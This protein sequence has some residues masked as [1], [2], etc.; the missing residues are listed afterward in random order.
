ML[1]ASGLVVRHV[2]VSDVSHVQLVEVG[3]HVRG[4]HVRVFVAARAGGAPRER[5]D[6]GCAPRDALPCA[7]CSG[8]HVFRRSSSHASRRVMGPGMPT[9]RRGV[10][11]ERRPD[12]WTEAGARQLVA[13]HERDGLP[14]EVRRALSGED[15]VHRGLATAGRSAACAWRRIVCAGRC[16]AGEAG[17]RR[18]RSRHHGAAAA[19]GG[20]PAALEAAER[21]PRAQERDKGER[22]SLRSRKHF[23]AGSGPAF[24]LLGVARRLLAPW[25]T[26][27]VRALSPAPRR[28]GNTPSSGALPWPELRR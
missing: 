10:A 8:A 17:A 26:A 15:G 12:A 24:R 19:H 7:G 18:Q 11:R 27:A 14:V 28:G 6:Q 20:R 16:G 1:D 5:R 9:W 3:V 13:A 23:F 4:H 25:R 22:S 2:V 21:P